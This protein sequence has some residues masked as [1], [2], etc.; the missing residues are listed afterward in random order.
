MTPHEFF[1][2]WVGLILGFALMGMLAILVIMRYSRPKRN[3]DIG[4]PEEQYYRFEDYC[5][6]HADLEGYDMCKGC[7][8]ENAHDC[9]IVW[10][11]LPYKKEN[12]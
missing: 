11:N 1:Y 4:T 12:K 7:P 2:F 8:L 9:R 5:A 6:E 3:Y 10:M